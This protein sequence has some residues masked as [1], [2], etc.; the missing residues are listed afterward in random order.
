MLPTKRLVY[1]AVVCLALS[2]VA[3]YYTPALLWWQFLIATLAVI[4]VVDFSSLIQRKKITVSREVMNTLSLGSWISVTLRFHNPASQDRQIDVYDHYPENAD[5]ENLPVTLVIPANGWSEVKYR[6]RPLKRG[7]FKFNLTQIRIHSLMGFWKRNQFIGEY[8]SVRVYPN[9]AAVMKYTLLAMDQRLSQIG[10]VKKR[11]RGEGQ[12]FHQLREY[13]EGD[14][15]RQVDWKAS[16]RI[17]KLISRDYQEERDQQ[18]LFLVDCGRR[19]L[20]EDGQLSHF[21]HTLNAILLLSHVALRQGDAVG[22][23]TFSGEER[24][25]SPRKSISSINH[26]LNTIYDLQPGSYSPDYTNAAS[27]LMVHQ[28]RRALVVLITNLRDEDTED[29]MPAIK[30][31]QKRHLVLLASLKEKVIDDMMQKPVTD[32]DSAID[33]AAAQQYAQY[34]RQ[35]HQRLDHE[36]VLHLDV[37]PEQLPVTMVNYYMDI[38]SSG[39]L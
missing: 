35:T 39:R 11:R 33:H 7:D 10:I 20:S 32:F 17:R 3:S 21:D 8:S 24:W 27:K 12:D 15:L 34:R 23:M 13:R 16:S 2:L 14:S 22:L 37:N 5:Y 26:I 38:K 9:F 19:M 25:M 6:I 30:I 1:L 28:R 36:G 31:M 29:L 4:L 18:I